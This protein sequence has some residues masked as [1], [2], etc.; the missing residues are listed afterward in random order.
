MQEVKLK[1]LKLIKCT[2]TETSI[3][4]CGNKSVSIKLFLDTQRP[5]ELALYCGHF[6][7]KQSRMLVKLL[8]LIVLTAGVFYAWLL[9]L[10]INGSHTPELT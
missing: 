6:A 10:S 5:S 7:L 8:R 3:F 2:G 9:R 1:C 4:I